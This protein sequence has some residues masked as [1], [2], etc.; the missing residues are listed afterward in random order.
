MT[1]RASELHILEMVFKTEA[2]VVELCNQGVYDFA[3]Q[4]FVSIFTTAELFARNM[5]FEGHGEGAAG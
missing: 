5:G 4:I 3:T 1:R 2:S